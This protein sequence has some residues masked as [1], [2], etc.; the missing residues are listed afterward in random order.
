MNIGV[1]RCWN[2]NPTQVNAVLVG[3]QQGGQTTSNES[4][5][6]AGRKRPRTVYCGTPYKRPMSSSGLQLVEVMMMMMKYTKVTFDISEIYACRKLVF[7]TTTR[8]TALQQCFTDNHHVIAVGGRSSSEDTAARQ[9]T[10]MSY[11]AA[12][13]I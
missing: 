8:S 7:V 10:L 13:G 9:R 6:A 1:P 4:L 2:I 12:K 11:E 3:P 5:G